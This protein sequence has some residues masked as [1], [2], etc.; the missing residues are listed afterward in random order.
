MFGWKGKI[1]RI[2]LTTGNR[3]VEDLSPEL[4]R[5][6]VGGRGAGLKILMDEMDPRIDPL[7][8]EN[9]LVFATGPLTGT[10]VPAGGR[11]VV[12]SKSP[13]SGFI[14][15]PCCGGYFGPNLKYAGYDFLILE[16]KASSPVYLY[17]RDEQVELR[18]AEHLW[19]LWSTATEHALRQELS[20]TLDDWQL[21]DLSIVCIGPAGEN[22]VRFACIMA[23]GGRAA[24]RSGLGAVMGSKNLKAIVAG[25]TGSVEVADVEGYR[26]AVMGFLDEGRENRV[27][28]ARRMYGTWSLPGRANKSGTQATRN[29]Q[30]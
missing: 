11:F 29:F 16:G 21:N 19:G 15:N 27:L 26:Q 24:G 13:L 7:G 28:Y 12:V 18:P 10:G 1:L 3:S 30:E 4:C 5:E 17:I 14:A 9:K 20:E 2:D 22:G 8:P 23:D 25:G 6:F